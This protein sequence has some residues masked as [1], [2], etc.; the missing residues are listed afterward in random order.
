MHS[1]PDLTQLYRPSPKEP[2]R[3]L[4]DGPDA[5]DRVLQVGPD[6]RTRITFVLLFRLMGLFCSVHTGVTLEEKTI[7]VLSRNCTWTFLG[8]SGG[9]LEYQFLNLAKQLPGVLLQAVF[10]RVGDECDDLAERR[11]RDV[12]P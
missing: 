1:W 11:R 8:S 10:P 7:G 2:L 3:S 6:R 5:S 12:F 9:A 4:L